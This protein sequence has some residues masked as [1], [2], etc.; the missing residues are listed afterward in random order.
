MKK[1]GVNSLVETARMKKCFC[2]TESAVI[3]VAGLIGIIGYFFYP[4]TVVFAAVAAILIC[5]VLTGIFVLKQYSVGI[6]F[7][8]TDKD[9]LHITF[10][11]MGATVVVGAIAGA[12]IGFNSLVVLSFLIGGFFGMLLHIFCLL[13]PTSLVYLLFVYVGKNIFINK[14]ENT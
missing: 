4:I 13:I 1:D 9:F 8:K 3:C 11:S 5:C 14:H 2:A 12:I 6:P 10:A 7:K